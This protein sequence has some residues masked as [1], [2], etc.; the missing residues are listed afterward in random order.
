ML[1]GD[2][3]K[4]NRFGNGGVGENN[5][6][7]TVHLSDG[8]V[9]TIKVSQLGNASLNSRNVAADCPHG[10]VEFL[11]PAARDED[12]GTLFDEKLCRSQPNPFCA[13]GDDSDLTFELFGHYFSPLLLS[14]NSPAPMLPRSIT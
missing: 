6:D 12:I 10:L 5:I 9:E 11:L 1:F 3:R 2:G 14:W 13:A 7:S 8:L 4:G